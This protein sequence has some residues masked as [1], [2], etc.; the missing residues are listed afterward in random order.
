MITVIEVLQRNW[1]CDKLLALYFLHFSLKYNGLF[2]VGKNICYRPIYMKVQWIFPSSHFQ[3]L[4][5][6]FKWTSKYRFNRTI[7]LR[8][9]KNFY[10]KIHLLKHTYQH[11]DGCFWNY[12]T[13]KGLEP[14]SCFS[15]LVSTCHSARQLLWP[16]N[17]SLGYVAISFSCRNDKRTCLFFFSVISLALSVV[18]LNLPTSD[19]YLQ[20]F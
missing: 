18:L 1:W 4:F 9:L 19:S 14:R 10:L 12:S 11:D 8:P 15:L 2:Q 7:V 13:L 16:L 20:C 5:L 17:A 3:R 6:A